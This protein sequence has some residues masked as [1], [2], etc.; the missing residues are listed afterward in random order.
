MKEK[1]LI[2]NPFTD[3]GFKKSADVEKFAAAWVSDNI[4]GGSEFGKVCTDL[5]SAVMVF[6][7]EDLDETSQDWALVSSFI[8]LSN[9]TFQDGDNF[10]DRTLSRC[11]SKTVKSH[12]IDFL[13]APK[14]DRLKACKAVSEKIT[15]MGGV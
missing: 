9:I 3:C 8:N 7:Y 4:R 5:L 12:Y 2:K 10:L 14:A 1:I 13:S 6:M 11:N 15:K